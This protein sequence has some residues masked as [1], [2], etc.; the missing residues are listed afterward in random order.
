MLGLVALI[1]E[2]ESLETM[3]IGKSLLG[4]EMVMFGKGIDAVDEICHAIAHGSII[5]IQC[6]ARMRRGSML[7]A[8]YRS[9]IGCHRLAG[10]WSIHGCL[11]VGG[12][13]LV[14]HTLRSLCPA[15]QVVKCEDINLF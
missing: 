12:V 15:G 6:F 14:G 2:V 11:I 3:Q 9:L 10:P 4:R 13:S 1:Q 7:Y 5:S 8:P